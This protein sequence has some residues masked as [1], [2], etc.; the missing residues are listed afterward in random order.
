MKYLL[1]AC[2]LFGAFLAFVLRT[3]VPEGLGEPWK[4]RLLIATMSLQALSAR[5]RAYFQPDNPHAYI[6]ALRSIRDL[7]NQPSPSEIK[8]SNIRSKVTTFDG[9]RVRLYEPI[10]KEDSLQPALIFIHGGGNAL[11]SPDG[12]DR[13]TR[14]IAERLN[15]VVVSIDYRLSPEHLFPAGH[16]DCL[17]A[18][19][20]FLR[21]ADQDFSV[22]TS[23]VA[24]S[25]DS[26]GG[27]LSATV[28]QAIHDDQTLPN[29]KL[30]ILI[31]PVTQSLDLLT[32]SYQK[33]DQDFGD[34]GVLP[35]KRVAAFTSMHHLGRSD[36]LYMQQILSNEHI[37]EEFRLNS[38]YLRYVDHDVIPTELRKETR[39]YLPPRQG[40]GNESLWNQIKGTYLDPRWSPLLREDLSGLPQAFVT[41]CGFDSIRDDGIFYAKRLEA[42]GVKTKWK[43]YPSAFHGVMFLSNFFWFQVGEEMTK[44]M[45]EFI[46][47]NI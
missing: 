28:S 11:G 38:P 47:N 20:W 19:S 12:Y 31:Y 30:Q 18:T 36:P 44:D 8:G 23:R 9:V 46:Q 34:E 16:L 14:L 15:V 32:P 10:K 2:T 40:P 7:T 13:L 25:G 3:P 4:Y 5:I 29:L 27:H 35:R 26:A 6:Q 21:N 39:L 45:V 22:D 17:R 33:Y 1:F 24:I 42:A 43:H 41:T 37:I